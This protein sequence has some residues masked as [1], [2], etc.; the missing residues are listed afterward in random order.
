MSL[1]S[2]FSCSTKFNYILLKFSG[3]DTLEG[4][5]VHCIL[6]SGVMH[7]EE[8]GSATRFLYRDFISFTTFSFVNSTK[9]DSRSINGRTSSTTFDQSTVSSRST[10]R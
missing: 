6:F 1:E 5:I 3:K 2:S 8:H 9:S 4:H 10:R 7:A